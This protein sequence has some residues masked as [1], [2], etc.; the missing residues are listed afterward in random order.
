MNDIKKNTPTEDNVAVIIILFNPN[1]TDIDNALSIAKRY[2]CVI[3]DNSPQQSIIS[4][5]QY[6]TYIWYGYNIGIAAAQNRAIEA[7][8]GDYSFVVFMD[9]DSRTTEDYP[10]RIANEFVKTQKHFVNLATIGPFFTDGK[11]DDAYKSRIHKEVFI[12]PDIICRKNIISSGCCIS[13][14][15][16]E[17]V[18]LNDESL[19]I[20]FVDSEWCWRAVSKGYIC[21]MTTNIVMIHSIGRKIINIG[22]MKDVVSAPQRYFFQFRNYLWML[23][24][25]YVP[26]KWKVNNGIKNIIRL[27]YYPLFVKSGCKC[28]KYMWKGIFHGMKPNKRLNKV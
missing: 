7:I 20:D 21:C 3:F 14:E 15:V 12:A 5:P 26:G 1:S 10:I 25:D 23:R 16:L 13:R 9:Q 6:A 17:N 22:P 27:F 18:G 11:S 2:K 19:F 8:P 28:A 4:I 24:R